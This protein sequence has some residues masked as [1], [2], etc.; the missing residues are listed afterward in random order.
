MYFDI[1][2]PLNADNE[3]INGY[4]KGYICCRGYRSCYGATVIA[5]T[6]GNILCLGA[7]SCGDTAMLPNGDT[8]TGTDIHNKPASCQHQIFL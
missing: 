6:F 7:E 5:S 2:Y 1:G 4:N 8:G 3:L